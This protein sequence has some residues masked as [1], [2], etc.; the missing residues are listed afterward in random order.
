M[1]DTVIT[2]S[3]FS[4]MAFIQNRECGYTC[5]DFQAGL[6]SRFELT[7]RESKSLIDDVLMHQKQA[8]GEKHSLV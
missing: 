6:H 7:E 1:I 4:P 5:G 2:H 3:A 8:C